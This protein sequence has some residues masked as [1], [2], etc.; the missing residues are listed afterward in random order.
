VIANG[1]V[2]DGASI[3]RHGRI[4][5]LEHRPTVIDEL[6]ACKEMLGRIEDA[7]K[8]VKPSPFLTWTLGNHDSRFETYLAA[9]AP[10]YEFVDGFH[11]KDHFP[12]WRPCWA[13][14]SL[15]CMPGSGMPV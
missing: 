6:N 1:D 2:F 9:V 3:S 12:A 5:F 14:Y 4:G 7:C 13:V 8:T 11:L 10:E 15:N